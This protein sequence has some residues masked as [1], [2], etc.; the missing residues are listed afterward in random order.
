MNHN[1]SN[2]RL[3]PRLWNSDYASLIGLKKVLQ[4]AIDKY[5]KPSGTDVLLDYGCGDVPYRSMFEDRVGKYIACDLY[6]NPDADLH[7]ELDSIIPTDDDSADIVLSVQVLEHVRHVNTYL[8]EANRVLK[9]DGLLLLSTHGWWTYHPFPHDYW[10]WTS[11]GL[12]TTLAEHGFEVVEH[13][14]ILGMLAYSSQLRV[15]TLKGILYERGGI[16]GKFLFGILSSCY[17]VGMV[18][19][20]KVTP[21]SIGMNNSAIYLMVARKTAPGTTK[22]GDDSDSV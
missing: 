3:A 11:E 19:M 2:R 16:I 9:S 4:W 13:R 15:Q 18:L 1:P 20:D 6:G 8:D 17:Q 12:R 14:W 10:R 22:A 21:S 5:T 7:Y